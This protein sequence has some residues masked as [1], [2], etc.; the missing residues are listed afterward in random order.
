VCAGVCRLEKRWSRGRE[1]GKGGSFSQ[2]VGRSVGRSVGQ[3][4]AVC[5][6]KR[7]EGGKRRKAPRG[8]HSSVS[9]SV[10]RCAIHATLDSHTHPAPH[11]MEKGVGRLSLLPSLSI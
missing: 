7:K 8:S 5:I 6:R 3:L 11:K 2:S 4:R 1:G 9:Q 10:G